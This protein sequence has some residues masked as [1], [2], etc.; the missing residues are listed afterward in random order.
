MYAAHREK[1]RHKCSSKDGLQTMDAV[2]RV[3]RQQVHQLDD[4]HVRP[5]A[6][7]TNTSKVAEAKPALGEERYCFLTSTQIGLF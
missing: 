3:P 6:I 1:H 2:R 4:K 7:Q 5:S